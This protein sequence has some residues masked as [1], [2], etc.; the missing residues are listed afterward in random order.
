MV[1][2]RPENCR[3]YPIWLTFFLGGLLTFTIGQFL[4]M[5]LTIFVADFFYCRAFPKALIPSRSGRFLNLIF[6]TLKIELEK[7]QGRQ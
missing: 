6:C 1:C 2:F 4:T 3:F 7:F 5:L